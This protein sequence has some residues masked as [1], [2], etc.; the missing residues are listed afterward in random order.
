[1]LN[2]NNTFTN[3][4]KVTPVIAFHKNTSLREII[5]TNIISHNQ[6]PLKVKQNVTKGE[7]IPCNTSRCP[8]YQ[9]IIAAT[10]FESIQTKE[11]FNIYNIYPKV[12][13]LITFFFF[14]DKSFF[15]LIHN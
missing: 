5:G 10:I 8:S 9:Q 7:C 1:M 13:M 14:Y 4:F 11:K 6:E 2:I 12:S 3:V 15:F